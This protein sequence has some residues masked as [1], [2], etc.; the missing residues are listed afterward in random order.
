[1]QPKYYQTPTFQTKHLIS[2][3]RSLAIMAMLASSML[4]G[5]A[6]A[7]TLQ[8][9]YNFGDGPGTTT[10]SSGP[11]AVTLNMVSGVYPGTAVDAHGPAGSGV[12]Q[13]GSCLDMTSNSPAGNTGTEHYAGIEGSATLG[14]LG[15]ITN[16]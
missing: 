7:Q 6:F 4:L 8:F 14:T 2:T 13:Q 16:F 5:T 9:E 10:T 15:Q 11:L 12:Q 3:L 1:M